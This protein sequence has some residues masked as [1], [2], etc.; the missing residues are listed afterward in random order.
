MPLDGRRA[1]LFLV[2]D[3]VSLLT[4]TYL[5]WSFTDLFYDPLLVN[6]IGFVFSAI[7]L[8]NIA[9]HLLFMAYDTFRKIKMRYRRYKASAD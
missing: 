9:V 3:D 2:F 8:G 7:N 6:K 5:L 1:N 4:L